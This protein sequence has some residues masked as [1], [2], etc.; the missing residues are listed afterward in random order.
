MTDFSHY[1]EEKGVLKGLRSV[2]EDFLGAG[3]QIADLLKKEIKGETGEIN[4]TGDTQK[5]VD[6]AANEVLMQ[7]MK[8]NPHTAEIISEETKTAEK[9]GCKGG[10]ETYST[11]F[12]PIDGSSIADVNQA[13]GSII[14]I[15]KGENVIG[16]S[17]RDLAAALYILYG[18]RLTVMVSVGGGT[19]EFLYFYDKKTYILNTTNIKLK[20]EYKMFAP[21]NLRAC[22]SEKWYLKLLEYWA[23]NQY[24]LRY[25]GGM[26]S[27]I[28]HILRK[29]GG[30][31]S[32]PAYDG[33]PGG[34][35]RLVYECNP[36]AYLIEQA[37]GSALC[38]RNQKILDV[39]ITGL[40]QRTPFFAGSSKEVEKIIDF[41]NV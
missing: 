32:Y 30:I 1:L 33:Y 27:D 10:G 37:G 11:A 4:V 23:V 34:K 5:K 21:G 19:D 2:L 20:E 40:H 9:G 6:V 3:V 29:N 36:M 26:V 18:P 31:F 8:R 39:K 15:Y 38:G 24:K 13:V 22:K 35:L 14:G 41:M 25:S 17:G 28:N 12:D 16:A 7:I